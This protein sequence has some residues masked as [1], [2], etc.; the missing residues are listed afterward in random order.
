MK[1]RVNVIAFPLSGNPPRA[2]ARGEQ[3]LSHESACRAT[4]ETRGCRWNLEM[5][6]C[7]FTSQHHVMNLLWTCGRRRNSLN[8]DDDIIIIIIIVWHAA[9]HINIRPRVIRPSPAAAHLS[10]QLHQIITPLV[11]NVP[12]SWENISRASRDA[13]PPLL[14]LLTLSQH[15]FPVSIVSFQY[16]RCP[17][18]HANVT[19]MLTLASCYVIVQTFPL[20]ML[21]S[22]NPSDASWSSGSEYSRR[23]QKPKNSF[24]NCVIT[25]SHANCEEAS[26]KMKHLF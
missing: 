10:A 23:R 11:I 9:Q 17:H 5:F 1:Q 12:T 15:S 18:W 4:L 3:Q 22:S 14:K 2:P 6:F 19:D 16:A 26:V 7:F 20:S 24:H 21:T 13:P 25:S 8:P